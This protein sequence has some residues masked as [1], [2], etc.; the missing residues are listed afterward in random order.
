MASCEGR[1]GAPTWQ[2]GLLAI[3]G[4]WM[5]ELPFT[6]LSFNRKL[7][8]TSEASC[9]TM[10]LDHRCQQL[11]SEAQPYWYELGLFADGERVW[12][13]PIVQLE[14]AGGQAKLS[15]RDLSTWWDIRWLRSDHLDN[16]V[17]GATV[18]A[19]YV[20]DGMAPADPAGASLRAVLSGRLVY[21]TVYAAQHKSVGEMVRELGASAI[22]WTFLDRD[23]ACGASVPFPD[24]AVAITDAHLAAAPTVLVDG[25]AY[26]SAVLV[27]G[28]GSTQVGDTV[29]AYSGGIDTVSY[30]DGTS[31]QLLIERIYRPSGLQSETDAQNQADLQ[32][33]SQDPCPLVLKQIALAPD[34]P[35]ELSQLVAG[36][37]V[38]VRLDRL[39]RPIFTQMRILQVSVSVNAQQQTQVQ[40]DLIPKGQVV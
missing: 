1:L 10:Q 4:G 14:L 8:D 22:D 37:L 40:L 19:A 36:V 31:A 25:L 38:E 2:A 11:L 34:A 9:T 16:G 39:I 3:G 24:I 26:A 17:D 20:A 23:G 12:S 5:V 13:G 15:A 6:D 7:D 21:R 35:I 30:P 28:D 18:A 33:A 27:C 29:F 32:L